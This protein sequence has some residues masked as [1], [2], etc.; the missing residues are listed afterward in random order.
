[1][2]VSVLPGAILRQRA[3]TK[4]APMPGVLARVGTST[5]MACRDAMPVPRVWIPCWRPCT[6]LLGICCVRHCHVPLL[7]ATVLPSPKPLRAR[8]RVRADPHYASDMQPSLCLLWLRRLIRVQFAAIL[9]KTDIVRVVVPYSPMIPCFSSLPRCTPS[10]CLRLPR[11]T[12]LCV[13]AKPLA[14]DVLV[15]QALLLTAAMP[16]PTSPSDPLQSSPARHRGSSAYAITRRSSPR[17][18]SPVTSSPRYSWPR[19]RT[20]SYAIVIKTSSRPHQSRALLSS[21]VIRR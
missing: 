5:S 13:H 6:L 15:S 1:M 11:C 2:F 18:P 16:S 17:H 4:F 3:T 10:C 20:S 14:T 21:C 7:L 12:V 9:P 19:H 8:C